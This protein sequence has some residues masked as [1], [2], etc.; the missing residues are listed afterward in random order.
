MKRL[1][2]ALAAVLFTM[3]A[4]ADAKD[5]K[6]LFVP[7]GDLTCSQARSAASGLTFNKH[8]DLR[9]TP[10]GQYI[11]GWVAGFATAINSHL[12]PHRNFFSNMTRFDMT[13]WIV[14]WCS[15]NSNRNKTLGDAMKSLTK[16]RQ[17]ID[18]KRRRQKLLK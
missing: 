9:A 18:I 1:A 11:L 3:S 10:A 5:I 2:L 15:R 12:R 13:T 17:G 16:G 7:C 14:K 8:G 6:D 4:P